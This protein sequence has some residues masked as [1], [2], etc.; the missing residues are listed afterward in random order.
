MKVKP[1]MALE[2]RTALLAGAFYLITFLAGIPPAA[3]LLSPVLDD[4]N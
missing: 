3:F 4:P 2:R 1:R